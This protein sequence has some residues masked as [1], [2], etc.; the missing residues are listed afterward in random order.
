D[1]NLRW[2]AFNRT[3]DALTAAVVVTNGNGLALR[4]GTAPSGS[5]VTALTPVAGIKPTSPPAWLPGS[6][7]GLV[8]TDNGLYAFGAAGQPR[9]VELP[10][11]V[12]G[13]ISAVAT[14]PDGQRIALVA[15]KKLYV[16]P[17]SVGENGVPT[18]WTERRLDLPLSDPTAV[19]WSSETALS[20][21]GA[22]KTGAQ[23]IFDVTV[24]G[25]RRNQRIK[26]VQGEITM[27]AAYPE[28]VVLG[29]P[30]TVLYQ[31]DDVIWLARGGLS[32]QLDR[33]ALEGETATPSPGAEEPSEP[34]SPFFV[35]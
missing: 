1:Q 7:T 29:R 3:P 19:A 27:I 4:V 13:P 22:D 11:G 34:T 35:Y 18:L 10:T 24:D 33:S 14:A 9:R 6:E 30:S 8:A 2:A 15:G 25:A 20:V 32:T 21:G 26:D 5:P 28:S 12:S 23:A 31:A 17:V 16:V